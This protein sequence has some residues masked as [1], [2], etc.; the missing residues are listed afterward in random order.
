MNKADLVYISR[1][2]KLFKPFY[3]GMGHV[4]MFHRVGKNDDQ[5]FT[6]D[7]QVSPEFLEITLEYFI[8]RKIDVVSLD[9]CHRRISSKTRAKRFVTF[10]FDDGYADNLTHA[11]PVFEKYNAPFAVFLTTGFPDHKIVLWW[12]LL[13]NLVMN[14]DKVEFV[15]GGRSFLYG[16]ATEDEK[17][18]A[19]WK[20]RRYIMQSKQEELLPR[21]K[22]IF[23]TDQKGLLG[24]TR[25]MALSWKQVRELS[26]HPLVTIGSHTVNHM[27]LSQLPEEKVYTEIEDAIEIIQEKTGKPVAHLAYPYGIASTVGPREIKIASQCHVKTAFTTESS[28]LLKRHTKNLFAL[29]RIEMTEGWDDQYFDLYVNGFTPFVHKLIR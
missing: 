25:E 29:P 7:L 26:N 16:T 12:Y 11:L 21:L 13:E 8:S 23:S 15:D 5:V 22:N 6:G 9:E 28:N 10:T 14:V 20:I 1:L 27:A 24:L 3:S 17:K 19:F 2:Y 18:D 4:L